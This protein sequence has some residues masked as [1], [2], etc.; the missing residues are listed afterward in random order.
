M[1]SIALFTFNSFQENTYVLY[2]ETK[3]C[4]IIDPGCYTPE[5]RAE[6]IGFIEQE[7]LMPVKLINTHCHI[8][9]VLGNK[10]IADKYQLK[11]EMHAL[12]IPTLHAVPTYGQ[13]WGI[14][15]EPS[16][17]PEI[18]LEEGNTV[19]FG[20]STLEVLFTPGHSNGSISFY[21]RKDR[22][23]IVGDVLF[24][25]SIGRTDIPGGNFDTLIQSIREKL[26]ILENSTKVYPGHGPSTAIGFEKE[27]N[28]FL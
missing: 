13:K 26:F 20:N 10:F 17:E 24:Y 11:L 3:Q 21:C 15:A 6:L 25:Q 14:F 27:H 19:T 7:G 22:F 16:P 23:V 18:L 4:I 2:D 9:H 5:E 8:D 28:P 1:I 12:D